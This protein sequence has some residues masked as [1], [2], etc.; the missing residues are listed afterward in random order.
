[1][2]WYFDVLDT[3]YGETPQH[4]VW[5]AVEKD[6]PYAIGIYFAQEHD[7]E[8]ARICARRHFLRLVE[9]KRNNY[10]PDYGAT[11]EP[12]IMPAWAKR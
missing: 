3:L 6:P 11:V 2:P 10:W 12:L 1:M 8:R 5:L 7:I 4:W 9:A